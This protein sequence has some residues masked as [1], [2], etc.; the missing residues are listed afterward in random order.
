MAGKQKICAMVYGV[1]L[2]L[3][4]CL[5]I[6]LIPQYGLAGAACASAFSMVFEAATLALTVYKRLNITI[7]VF[8]ARIPTRPAKEET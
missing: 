7:F 1:T 4:I 2:V 3:N 5:R 6:I 8:A